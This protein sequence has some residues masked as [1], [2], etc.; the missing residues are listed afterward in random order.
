MRTAVL[1]AVSALALSAGAWALAGSQAEDL[2]RLERAQA[3]ADRASTDI[4]AALDAIAANLRLG[5]GLGARSQKIRALTER[6]RASL[7]ELGALL[8]AQRSD[9]AS[10]RASLAAARRH[11]AALAELSGQGATLLERTLSAL[12]RLSALARSAALDS[13]ALARTARYGARLAE[14]SAKAFSP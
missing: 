3:R 11:G 13:A 6:Q 12:R 7:L 1:V 9:L 10:T 4:A 5:A 2:R 14:G 8:R